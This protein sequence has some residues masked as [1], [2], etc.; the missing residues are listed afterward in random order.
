MFERNTRWRH[1]RLD[2]KVRIVA[3]QE[4]SLALRLVPDLETAVPTDIL[5]E[6]VLRHWSTIE[7]VKE[8]LPDV[9]PSRWDM[10][11]EDPFSPLS[12]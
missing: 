12:K 10:I 7:L 6:V 1:R 2:L 9:T 8:F 3:N 5:N 11:H 4:G